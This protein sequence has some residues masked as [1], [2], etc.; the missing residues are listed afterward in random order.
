MASKQS[1]MAQLTTLESHAVQSCA[2]E[3]VGQ[4]CIDGS[5]ANS[6]NGPSVD[7]TKMN[8]GSRLR[9]HVA[10]LLEQVEIEDKHHV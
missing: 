8:V 6:V 9:M 4:R 1:T 7:E 10:H 3:V 2:R 5:R